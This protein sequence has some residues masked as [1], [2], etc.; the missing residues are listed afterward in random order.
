LKVRVLMVRLGSIIMCVE[1]Y[2]AFEL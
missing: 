2:L 1:L